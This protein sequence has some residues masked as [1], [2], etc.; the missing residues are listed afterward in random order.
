MTAIPR[1]AD[2]PDGSIVVD[3]LRG[4]AWYAH[5]PATPRRWTVTGVGTLRAVGDHEV[6][7]AI[8]HGAELLRYGGP[9]NA[10]ETE[11]WGIR[12]VKTDGDRY[13]NAEDRTEAEFN[14]DAV[15]TALAGWDKSYGSRSADFLSA[16]VV[17]RTWRR[18]PD[19][20]EHLTPWQHIRDGIPVED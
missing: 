3:D 8:G 2:L 1:A 10:I 14:A 7:A 20:S 6:D 16:A 19:G 9:E 12:Y 15:A 18:Y 5:K 11:V 13:Q 17:R 4:L